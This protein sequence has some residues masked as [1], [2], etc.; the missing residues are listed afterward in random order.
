VKGTLTEPVPVKEPATSV[1]DKSPV[2]LRR[3][4]ARDLDDIVLKALRKEPLRLGR[5]ICRRRSP[6]S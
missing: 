5:A 6:L 4:F 2:R 1:S 3:L